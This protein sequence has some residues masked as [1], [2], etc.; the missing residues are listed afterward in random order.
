MK[1][2]YT[3]VKNGNLLHGYLIV[4]AM[5]IPMGCIN[6]REQLPANRSIHNCPDWFH[7][8]LGELVPHEFI[9]IGLRMSMPRKTPYFSEGPRYLS[10]FLGPLTPYPRAETEYRV[11][12]TVDKC[13]IHRFEQ[14]NRVTNEWQKWEL[15]FHPTLAEYKHEDEQLLKK[16]KR[17]NTVQWPSW[18]FMRKDV[19][20]PNTKNV[21]SVRAKINVHLVNEKELTA[22]RQIIE[23]IHPLIE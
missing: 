14:A 22:I 11:I 19:P 1:Q 18:L 17:S 4:L 3:K 15:S 20:V 5:F 7:L 9:Q 21:L 2:Y 13:S 23:S 8:T 12:L 6:T 10:T 16:Y